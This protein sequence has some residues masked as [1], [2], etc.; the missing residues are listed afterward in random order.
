[1]V[2]SWWWLGQGCHFEE[3]TEFEMVREQPLFAKEGG[4][5]TNISS[6]DS[7]WFMLPEDISQEMLSGECNWADSVVVS[8][9]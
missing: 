3:E 9:F 8:S 6:A 1:M 7:D 4:G 5:W 2:L